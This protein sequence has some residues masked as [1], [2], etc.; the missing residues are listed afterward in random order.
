MSF[1]AQVDLI[2]ANG[3]GVGEVAREIVTG[4]RIDVG[5]RRPWMDPKTGRSYITVYVGGDPTHKASWRNVP[6][7]VNA[8]LRRDEWKALDDALVMIAEQRLQ[9]VADLK[10]RGLVYTLGNGMGTTVLEWHDVSDALEAGISMDGVNRHQNDRPKYEHN[11]MPLPIVSCDYQLNERELSV[12]RRMGNPLDTTLAE[13]AARKVNEKLE[14]M[15]FTNTTYSYGGKDDKDRNTIY[16]YINHPDRNQVT[17]ST[18]GSWDDDSATTAENIIDSVRAMKQ[19]SLN[20]YHFGPWVLYIPATYETRMDDDFDTSGQSTQTIRDRILKINGVQDVKVIDKLPTDNV[21]LVE[22]SSDVVR[23]VNGL[24]MQNVEW[25]T[26]GGMIHKYKVMT[27]Q[28]PQIRA[29][30]TGKSGV[31]HMA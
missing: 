11:Y 20:A 31:V 8:T 2:T 30:Q 28:V 17:L 27:I 22:M 14:E 1:N 26:E 18:Y 13:R 6:L 29:D 21:L 3:Q 19:A 16:S 7:S 15:L 23:W 9:G 25:S 24:S 12:S 5:N 4:N 10:S